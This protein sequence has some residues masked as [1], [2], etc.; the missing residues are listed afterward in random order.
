[1]SEGISFDDDHAR[2][3][4][5]VGIPYPSMYKRPVSAKASY[6]NEQR[7]HR[8]RNILPGREWYNQEAFRAVSQAIGR[9]VSKEVDLFR[10]SLCTQS[11][12]TSS[13]IRCIRHASDYGAVILLDARYC[14]DDRFSSANLPKWMRHSV[15]ELRKGAI[16]RGRDDILGGYNGLLKEMGRFFDDAEAHTSIPKAQTGSSTD[17]ATNDFC[18]DRVKGIW[19]PQKR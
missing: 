10:F 8:G 4:I 2:A 19:S 11:F 14:E 12:L 7:R 5:C 3:V 9:Y 16:G 15:R 18:F 6:N 17:A 1:M 13:V